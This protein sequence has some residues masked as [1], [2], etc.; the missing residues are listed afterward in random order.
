[1]GQPLVFV[2]T[3]TN[4][5]GE[6]VPLHAPSYVESG[7]TSEGSVFKEVYGLDVSAIRRLPPG[8]TV[9]Y[10]MRLETPVTGSPG[11]VTVTWALAMADP[12]GATATVRVRPSER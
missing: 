12:V 6:T 4:P 1:V 9:R 11:T 2:V 5:T 10:E 7:Q 8:E 3:L